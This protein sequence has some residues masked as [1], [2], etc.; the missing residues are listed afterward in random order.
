MKCPHC[1][2]AFHEDKETWYDHLASV[3]KV[4]GLVFWVCGVITCPECLEVIVCLGISLKDDETPEEWQI[5]Y[6]RS[7][8]PKVSSDIPEPLKADYIEAHQVLPISP[9]AS[10]AL[11]R[12]VLQSILYEQGY[13]HRNLFDQIKEVLVEK[14]P[15]KVLPTGLRSWI[16][17]VRR[18]GNFSAHPITDLTSLQ[19]IDVDPEEAEWCLQIIYALFDHYYVEPALNAKK[20]GDLDQKLLRAGIKPIGPQANT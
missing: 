14:H 10:A 2:V 1:D 3:E 7:R 16:Q 8:P 5:I 6:P 17:A 20:L 18:F 19:V 11:S 9:K 15:D 12:R 4:E 13:N